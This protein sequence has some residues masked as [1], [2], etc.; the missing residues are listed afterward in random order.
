MRRCDTSGGWTSLTVAA[1]VLYTLS[2]LLR[3]I[4][5]V[6]SLTGIAAVDVSMKCVWAT[7]FQNQWWLTEFAGVC[8]CVTAAV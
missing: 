3:N 6:T 2:L 8:D 5:F 4:R 1:N 7:I